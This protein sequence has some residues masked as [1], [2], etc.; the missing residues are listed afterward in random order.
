MDNGMCGMASIVRSLLKQKQV[1]QVHTSFFAASSSNSETS[2]RAEKE[3]KTNGCYPI[4]RQQ[5]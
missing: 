1:G 4:T 5:V 2:G 3:D